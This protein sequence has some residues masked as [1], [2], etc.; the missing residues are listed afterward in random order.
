MNAPATAAAILPAVL[1]MPELAE[2]E[3]YAGLVLEGGAWH[4]LILLPAPEPKPAGWKKQ[5]EWAKE[6]GGDLPTRP[7][8]SVLYANLRDRFEKEWYWSSMPY[9]GAESWAWCQDF[10]YGLQDTRRKDDKFRARAVRR[11]AI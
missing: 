6:Q 2:G 11:V 7:E 9:A 1:T 10:Y 5:M 4:H 3:L 8:Q